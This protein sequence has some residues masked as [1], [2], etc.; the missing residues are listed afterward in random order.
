MNDIETLKSMFPSL[1][2]ERIE[3]IVNSVLLEQLE[4]AEEKL[5]SLNPAG[6][7]ISISGEPVIFD[8]PAETVCSIMRK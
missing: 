3:E 1:S 4:Q 2:E 5:L 7:E 8:I 6:V